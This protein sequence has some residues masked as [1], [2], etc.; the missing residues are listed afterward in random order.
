MRCACRSLL[1][2]SSRFLPNSL[3]GRNLSCHSPAASEYDVIVVGGGHAGTEASH[4]A[5]RMGVRTLLITHKKEKIGE[6][7][8]NPSFGGIGKGHLLREIDA[9][10]GVCP[11]ICDKSGVHYRVLNTKK[12]PA[13]WGLRAQ[14]DRDLYKKNLQEEMFNVPDLN[15]VTG[16]VEDLLLEEGTNDGYRCTGVILAD[17]TKF[18]SKCVVL[19]TGTFLRANIN[20]GLECTPAGR[21]GDE[22]A[23]GLAETLARLKFPIGRLRTGTPPRLERSSINYENL[24]YVPGDE[25]PIPFSFLN[26]KVWIKPEDQLRCYKT[27]TNKTVEDICLSSLNRNR[28]VREEVKGPRYCPS[29]ESKSI[30]FGG[31]IHLVWLE[32][33]GLNSSVIYPGG[34]SCTMPA[35]MQ[36]QM[37]H[38]IAGLENAVLLRP[39]YGVE[40]EFVDPREL[41]PTLETKKVCGLF[42]AGQINGTTGY[43]EAAA[44]GILAGINAAAKCSEKPDFIVSR[45]DS[46]LGVLVDDLTTLG[47]DE[48]YR[49]FTARSEFRTYLRPDNADLRLT[50]KGYEIGCVSEKR[51]NRYCAVEDQFV[52]SLEVLESIEKSVHKW[53]KVLSGNTENRYSGRC[54]G[55]ELFSRNENLTIGELKKAF[56]EE[57]ENVTDDPKI[58]KRLEY[59]GLYYASQKLYSGLIDDI[60][61]CEAMKIP[62]KLNYSDCLIFRLDVSVFGWMSHFSSNCLN[63]R[64]DVSFFGW[65]SQFSAGCLIFRLIV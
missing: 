27:Y 44:Q 33:E 34:L 17:G 6:M 38:A 12:G 59:E 13:V 10:D 52:K 23:M 39:G 47:A 37:I 14:I 22:P 51:F 24:D 40:Y 36:E 56:P 64:L 35:E 30:K 45:T 26:D 2:S 1:S 16:S 49:M 19:T 25:T 46:Y 58:Q 32:P 20:I 15:I 3:A 55:I 8:C 57:F 50:R 63:F 5:V 41:Y 48:P 60:R 18:K 53:M 28:H 11:R 43:E 21:M 62:P 61:D 54:K 42:F 7:S 31:K 9:L 4:A 29:I 65:M